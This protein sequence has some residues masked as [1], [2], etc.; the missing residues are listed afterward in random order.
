MYEQLSTL[1]QEQ[2]NKVVSVG[3]KIDSLENTFKMTK[4]VYRNNFDFPCYL[5]DK[6]LKISIV[7][8]MFNG[9]CITIHI[10]N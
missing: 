1:S 5:Y 6:E 8:E 10:L 2:M 3:T 7:K 9:S 4:N